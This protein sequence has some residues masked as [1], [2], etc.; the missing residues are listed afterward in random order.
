M[1]RDLCI[2]IASR[3]NA[4]EIAALENGKTTRVLK[5]PATRMGVEA[6]KGFLAAHA[7]PVRLAVAGAAAVSLALALG[8]VPGRETF[9]VAISIASQAPALAHYAGHTP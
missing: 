4:Y 8:N 3:N 9:I 5:F 7:K 6:I 2:G 1:T